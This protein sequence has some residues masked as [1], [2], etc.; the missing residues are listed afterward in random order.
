[1]GLPLEAADMGD[2]VGENGALTVTNVDAV[3]WGDA[4]LEI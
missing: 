2:E 1:V 4:V 3:T